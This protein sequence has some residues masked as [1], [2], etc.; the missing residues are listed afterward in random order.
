MPPVNPPQ[1]Q[2]AEALP[3]G[4]DVLQELNRLEALRDPLVDQSG[5]SSR[6]ARRYPV[7]E[8]ARLFPMSRRVLRDEGHT[9]HLRDIGRS[10]VGFLSR[11]P[12]P[13]GRDFRIEF[14]RDGYAVTE[15]GVSVKYCQQVRPGLFLIGAGFIATAGLLTTL[16]VDATD[17][18]AEYNGQAP[19]AEDQRA[20]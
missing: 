12:L 11:E 16:G 17:L 14:R 19:A 8:D 5:Q 13:I 1:I 20:A 15:S 18:E 9:V 6:E 10:G 2:D 4:G 7:R 3:A